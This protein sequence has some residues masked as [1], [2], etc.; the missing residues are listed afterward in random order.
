MAKHDGGAAFPLYCVPGDRQNTSGMSLRQYYAAHAPITLD[1][2]V[3]GLQ[4]NGITQPKYG[5]IMKHLAQMR[6]AYADEM[7]KELEAE[8]E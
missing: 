6:T 8:D 4:D 3:Q 5:Q 7:L 1:D 2:A